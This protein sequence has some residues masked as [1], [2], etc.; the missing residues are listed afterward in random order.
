MGIQMIAA[1]RVQALLETASMLRQVYLLR[2]IWAAVYAGQGQLDG[3]PRSLVI[4]YVTI[5]TIQNW[6]CLP[7]ALTSR[8]APLGC[9]R[10]VVT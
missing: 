8:L 2:A 9:S 3:R 6:L 4:A 5:A 10:L 7:R 1:Y